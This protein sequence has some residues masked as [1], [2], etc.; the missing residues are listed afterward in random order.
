MHDSNSGE[1]LVFAVD[2]TGTKMMFDIGHDVTA[3]P[4]SAGNI[5]SSPEL[6]IANGVVGIGTASPVTTLH[7]ESTK[8]ADNADNL[9]DFHFVIR[10]PA[11]D[12]NEEV[13]LGF[14]ISSGT[15]NVGAGITH[16]RVGSNS[17]GNIHFYT[18]NSSDS[19]GKRVT[20]T[21]D[22]NVGIGTT[23]PVEK[24][25]IDSG[26]IAL[27]NFGHMSC[28]FDNTG[29][30][31]YQWKLT[32][33]TGAG[34]FGIN[35]TSTTGIPLIRLSSD[36][37]NKYSMIQFTDTGTDNAH[38]Y[39]VLDR[40]SELFSG[41]AQNDIVLGAANSSFVAIGTEL[42]ARWFMDTSGNILH[43]GRTTAA[44]EHYFDITGSAHHDGD[45]IAFSSAIGS[46]I[47]LKENIFEISG[48]LDKVKKLRPIEFD[49]KKK[50]QRPHEL[51]L[52]AQEVE[53]IEPLLVKDVEA[54]GSVTKYLDGDG[55]YKTVDYAKLTILLTDA[56]KEQQ[57]QIDELKQEIIEIKNG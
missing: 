41:A 38:G 56:I 40:V 30:D 39:L 20:I 3:N 49:W 42:T 13:G 10:N 33:D 34:G 47:R 48:S 18:R 16:E 22:G 25:H 2:N 50:I 54:V 23:S 7:V 55:T 14:A 15:T 24:F 37:D 29:F 46:D 43:M 26:D 27:T 6:T 1:T 11:N 35:M 12:N 36:T 17:Y 19:Y 4:S 8:N 45:V 5:P 32:T 9:N 44:A 21:H 28:S 53:K 52:I 31:T 57:K 51:G